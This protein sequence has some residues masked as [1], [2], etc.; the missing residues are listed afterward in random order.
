MLSCRANRSIKAVTANFQKSCTILQ[1]SEVINVESEIFDKK[2]EIFRAV[3]KV[4][5]KHDILNILSANTDI[6]EDDE[7]DA[8][9]IE[10]INRCWYLDEVESVYEALKSIFEYWFWERCCSK[11]ALMS[12]AVDVRGVLKEFRREAE[13]AGTKKQENKFVKG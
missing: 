7:Y 3:R 6:E 10:I 4:V 11:D 1:I 5:N 12:L 9:V 13:K 2:S 8:E